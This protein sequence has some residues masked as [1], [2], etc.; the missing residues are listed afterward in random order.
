MT[1][2]VIVLIY[3]RH[4]TPDRGMPVWICSNLGLRGSDTAL[5]I[6][7]EFE[8]VLACGFH[9]LASLRVCIKA[10]SCKA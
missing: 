2:F 5:V 8:T 6:L 9:V 3:D 7:I 10:V 4:R 1:D